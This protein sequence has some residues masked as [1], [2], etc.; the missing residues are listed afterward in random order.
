MEPASPN[1][2]IKK[3]ILIKA[4]AENVWRV[5][6]DRAVTLKMGGHYVSGWQINGTLEWKGNDGIKYTYGKI[7]EI[8]PF[9]LLKHSLYDMKT[10]SRVTSII[11]Y[12]FEEV[13]GETLLHAEEMLTFDMRDDQFEEAIEGWDMALDTVKEIAESISK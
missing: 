2:Q 4:P 11:T 3:T 13:N 1:R 9:Q 12:A 7:L 5:F 8:M 6:T 10:K